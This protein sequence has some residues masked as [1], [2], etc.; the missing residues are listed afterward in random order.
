MITVT[1]NLVLL[2][3]QHVSIPEHSVT[4]R[5]TPAMFLMLCVNIVGSFL[6]VIVIIIKTVTCN[7]SIKMVKQH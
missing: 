2:T 3:Y 4:S 7:D 5:S 6:L 1:L